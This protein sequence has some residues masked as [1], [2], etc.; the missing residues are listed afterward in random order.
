MRLSNKGPD[1]LERE[2]RKC[3][4]PQT[5]PMGN[6]R[7]LMARIKSN[8]QVYMH[9][10]TGQNKVKTKTEL[11]FVYPDQH[12]LLVCGQTKKINKAQL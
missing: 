5:F 2:G 12:I 10:L 9:T 8:T 4:N 1:H 11:L 7:D 6:C 3:S